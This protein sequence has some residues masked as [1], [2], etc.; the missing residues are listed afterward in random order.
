[1][2]ALVLVGRDRGRRGGRPERPRHEQADQG[3]VHRRRAPTSS[4]SRCGRARCRSRWSRKAAWRAR[5]T[6]TSTATSRAA[7]TIIRIT[8][9]GTR[10]K[11]G[12]IVCELD[13]AAL[14][15][16]LINQRITTK[17]AEANFHERQADPRGGRD[18]RRANTRRASSCRTSPTVEGEIK[19]AESDLS[20]AEDRLDWATRMF[21]KGYVSMATKV[22]EELNF[23]KAQFT[24]EQAQ[25]KKKVLVEYTKDKT[26]KELE[27]E[28]EKAHSDELAKQA[29]WELEKSKEN[30]AREADRRLHAH[31]PDRRPGRLRQRS[32]PGVRQQPAA[33][34]GRRDGPR[35]AEDHQH[36]R[37]HPDAGQR[38]GPRV[39]D[40]QDQARHEGADPGRRLRR[41]AARRRRSRTSPPCPTRP[42]SSAP[43]SRS[44]RPRS[45]SIDPLAGPPAGHDGRGEDPGR[46]AGQCAE[47]SGAG[48]PRSSMART[49]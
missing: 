3:P 9:E 35:A 32:Q 23:K 45:G 43:T 41:P 20:R 40:R 1:M 30:E 13:S 8:P 11:K 31:R 27:S 18:R 37:H 42:T 16:Q 26:I 49:T 34:R 47:R 14:K 48:D 25:S 39:A 38:Q 44:T 12:E 2:I 19:L 46:P 4:P 29:T 5:R 17:S 22:S 10:V 24:L 36:P 7:T 6:R 21:E 33:D 15:D 28:V